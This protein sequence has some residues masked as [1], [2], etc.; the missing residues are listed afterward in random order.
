MNKNLQTVF[1]VD[2][3]PYNGNDVRYPD[4]IH[5]NLDQ[6]SRGTGLTNDSMSNG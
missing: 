5:S 2:F 4:D 3:V 1:F 6:E